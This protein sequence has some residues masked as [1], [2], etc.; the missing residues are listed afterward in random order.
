MS[1]IA[2]ACLADCFVA[3]LVRGTPGVGAQLVAGFDGSRRGFLWR[4]RNNAE[5]KPYSLHIVIICAVSG[6]FLA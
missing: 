1:G 6:C 3:V 5:A 4:Y 2:A